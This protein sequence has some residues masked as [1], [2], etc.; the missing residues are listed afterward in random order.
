LLGKPSWLIDSE[1]S[2][3]MTYDIERI[4]EVKSIRPT[5][6]CLPNGAHTLA[7]K[8]G[9]LAL[10]ENVSLK[11]V[12]YVPEL[13]CNLLSVAKLCKDLKCAVTFV[14]ESCVLQDRTSRTLI[15]VGEQRDGVYYYLGAPKIKN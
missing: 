15:G 8:Q 1:V 5:P 3:H 9:T 13:N 7:E 4:K 10:G 6:I 14:S 11:E 2:C 12:L